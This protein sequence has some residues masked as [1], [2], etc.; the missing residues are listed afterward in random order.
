MRGVSALAPAV[1]YDIVM[2]FL[3]AIRL[4]YAAGKRLERTGW[5]A[6]TRSGRKAGTA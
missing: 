3:K 4:R 2:A 5:G 1:Y 6:K